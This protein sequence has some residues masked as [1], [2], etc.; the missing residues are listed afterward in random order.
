MK[1]TNTTNVITIGILFI[2][3][4]IRA[5]CK[6]RQNLDCI[7]WKREEFSDWSE[8]VARNFDSSGSQNGWGGVCRC[9]L[10]WMSCY[11]CCSC[12][13]PAFLPAAN[14]LFHTQA[15]SQPQTRV[16]HLW[17]FWHERI[18]EYICIK[19]ITRTNV[20]IYSYNFF[21]WNEWPNRYLYWKL[22][23]YSNI[24]LVFTL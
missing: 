2:S 23:E 13:P 22:C 10:Q 5:L 15:L 9:A 21:D 6:K 24:R 16:W 14:T 3:R 17:T 4:P 19:K 12:T 11:S 7:L 18:S 1:L 8:N 20:Q